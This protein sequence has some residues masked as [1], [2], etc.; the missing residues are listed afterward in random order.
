MIAARATRLPAHADVTP[1]TPKPVSPPESP[2]HVP[3]PVAP[4]IDKAALTKI[5]GFECR[6]E[7]ARS[8]LLS[9]LGGNEASQQ[10]VRLA[11]DWLAA[12][13]LADGSW[14][15]SRIGSAANPGTLGAPHTA[16]ALVVLAMAGAGQCERTADHRTSVYKGAQYLIRRMKTNPTTGLVSETSPDELPSRPMAAAALCEVAA[17][18]HTRAMLDAAKSAV[19]LL[20]TSQN[21]DGGWSATHIP[22][23]DTNH[24]SDIYA[25]GWTVAALATAK[26]AHLDVPQSSLDRAGAFLDSL[27]TPDRAGYRRSLSEPLDADATPL[28]FL[29]RVYLNWQPDSLEVQRYADQLARNGPRANG[30]PDFNYHATLLMRSRAGLVWAEWNTAMRDSLIARQVQ[31]GPDQG[32]WLVQGREELIRQGGRLYCTAMAALILESYYRYPPPQALLNGP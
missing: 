21:N 29:A 8:Q 28:G 19:N 11:M 31:E 30:D 27:Q 4:S 15:F 6:Q 17:S 20:A 2:S 7:P 14:D 23:A 24:P 18:G 22:G 13:Q 32:S 9:A 1:E 26:L 25:T 10:A 5:E 16:T 12:H 3:L